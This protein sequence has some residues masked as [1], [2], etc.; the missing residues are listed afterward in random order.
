MTAFAARQV[1]PKARPRPRHTG[2]PPRSLSLRE[3]TPENLSSQNFGPQVRQTVSLANSRPIAAQC[4]YARRSNSG[5]ARPYPKHTIVSTSVVAAMSAT[6]DNV[7]GD[8]NARVSLL[9]LAPPVRSGLD[10][11]RAGP[12]NKGRLEGRPATYLLP[13]STTRGT[14]APVKGCR[15]PAVEGWRHGRGR[16]ASDKPQG[17]KPRAGLGAVVRPARSMGI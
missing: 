16:Q 7:A 15:M 1:D 8:R 12:L 11:Q 4:R 9:T 13:V 14:T 10:L 3:K 6:P 5:R 2:N 17:R